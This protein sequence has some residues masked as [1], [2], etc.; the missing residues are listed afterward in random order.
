MKYCRKRIA[1]PA[2][3]FAVLLLCGG[4]SAFRAM[5]DEDPAVTQQKREQAKKRKEERVRSGADSSV[6]PTLFP[7]KE[8]EQ[9]PVF[10]SSLS[11]EER[12]ILKQTQAE[13]K[14]LE[15]EDE[16]EQIRREN[17][18]RSGKLSDR[19]FGGG[20]NDLF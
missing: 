4:C 6:F 10:S 9:E 5:F 12:A 20:V 3:F 19:V 16:V 15:S 11:P 1:F 14:R 18:E 2:F 17:R 7:K 8:K 13:S